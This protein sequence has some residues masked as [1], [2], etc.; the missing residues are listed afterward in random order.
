MAKKGSGSGP[1]INKKLQTQNRFEALQ[2]K[3]FPVEGEKEQ[4]TQKASEAKSLE[5]KQME[6]S[7]SQELVME[8]RTN[9]EEETEAEDMI[10]GDLDLDGLEEAFAANNPK[11]ISPLQVNLLEK[12]I[13]ITKTGKNLGVQKGSLKDVE[14]KRKGKGE[15]RGRPTNTHRIQRLGQKLISS[16][17][18]P[19][20]EAALAFKP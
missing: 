15:K 3:P 19:T 9:A 11:D 4:A 14:G 12:A 2:E 5:L 13:I 7:P 18:Y 16:G 17:Q 1:E 8:D 20:I 6:K 10:L